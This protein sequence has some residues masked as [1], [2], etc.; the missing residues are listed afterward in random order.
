MSCIAMHAGCCA[1]RA[2]REQPT[3]AAPVGASSLSA[4]PRSNREGVARTFA[5]A[6]RTQ[7]REQGAA[8]GACHRQG[9]DREAAPETRRRQNRPAHHEKPNPSKGKRRRRPGRKKGH[10]GAGR[11]RPARIDRT[12]DHPALR[13][14]PDCRAALPAAPSETRNRV[15]EGL[16]AASSEAVRHEIPRS[17]CANCQKLVEPVVTDAMPGNRISLYTFVLSAWLHYGTGMSVANVVR[18]LHLAGLAITPGGL[19][20]GWQRL[21]T[22]VRPAYDEILE[23]VKGSL[24]LYADETGWRIW[25]ITHWLWYFGSRYWSY[26]VID[27]RRG[28]AVVNRVLGKI[29]DGILITDFWGAYNAI[30]A[31]AKQKC[32]FH[33]FTALKKVDL[34]KPKNPQWR[35]FR[36][37]LARI[38]H[39]AIRLVANTRIDPPTFARRKALIA[40][41][42]DALLDEPTADKDAK[43]LIKRLR[44]HRHAMLT[45]LD[46]PA[47]VSPYNN[48]AEQQMR[49]PVIA[50]RI[51]QGN[52]ST[53]GAASQAILMSLFRSMELQGNDPVHEILNL[54]RAAIAGRAVHLP[55]APDKTAIASAAA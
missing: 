14:C 16:C 31:W 45:F 4:G 3:L 10:D 32:I 41:R 11:K 6:G 33:L 44:R 53:A 22:M 46:F 42:L 13:A 24:V 21:A 29:L 48:H 50:R 52:R 47:D 51:S 17:Y 15:I 28:T 7:D 49:Q 25:G 19:T 38:F 1:R 9:R 39:D 40:A 18:L 8:P 30:D 20:Q 55:P 26:Y 34:L 27:R 37:R 36:Q 2:L 35:D 54:A 12:E 5:R 23:N 43:R